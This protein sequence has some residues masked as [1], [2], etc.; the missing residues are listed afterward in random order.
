MSI[1]QAIYSREMTGMEVPN[2]IDKYGGL[3]ATTVLV[4]G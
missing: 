1:A 2:F 3:F 4:A